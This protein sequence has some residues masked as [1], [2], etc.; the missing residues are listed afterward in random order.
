MQGAPDLV[1]EVLSPS[2]ARQDRGEKRALY[3]RHGVTEY[4]LVDP[5]AETVQIH[6]LRGEALLPTDTFGRKETL[7]SP[8]LAGLELHLDDI[9][10]SRGRAPHDMVPTRPERQFS[11][12]AASCRF[13]WWAALGSNQRPS[14]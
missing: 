3:G 7:R 6:R 11:P 8:L 4:W 5:A 9:F 10:R 13:Y 14:D 2:T 12:I 1:V